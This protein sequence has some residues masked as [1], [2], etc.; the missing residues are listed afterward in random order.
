MK[1]FNKKHN[2]HPLIVVSILLLLS[3]SLFAEENYPIIFD[4][5]SWNQIGFE[6]IAEK[7]QSVDVILIGEIRDLEVARLAI[8]YSLSGHLVLSTLHSRN[9]S[10]AILRLKEFISSE[11]EKL[12]LAMLDQSLKGIL[13][14]NMSYQ[15]GKASVNF[16]WV[17]TEYR[18]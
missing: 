17:K 4:S 15:N 11:K 9:C 10:E 7:F 8:D 6:E 13:S 16:E 3:I 14:Q 18:V 12:S 5:K 2:V 1:L